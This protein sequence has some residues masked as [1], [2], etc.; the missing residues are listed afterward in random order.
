MFSGYRALE[1][2]RFLLQDPVRTNSFRKA[3]F[4]VVKEGDVV[5]DLGA[6]S[7][8]LSFF[9]YQAGAKKIYAIEKGNIIEATKRIARKN[10]M[11]DK[12]TFI[13]E[14][15]RIVRLPEKVD[16]IVSEC[17]GHFALGGSMISALTNMRD[18]YLKKG[19]VII[20][21]SISMFIV[22]VQSFRHYQHVNFWERNAAY[23]FDFHPAQ[24]MASNNVY[25]ATMKP[26]DFIAAPQKIAAMDLFRDH[27][28]EM[29]DIKAGFSIP[30]ACVMHG[31]CGWSEVDLCAGVSF[32]TSPA[33]KTTVWQQVFFPLEK[34]ISLK[35][36]SVV[37]LHLT[38]RRSE[39][40]LCS[41]L[42]WTI[43][44][45]RLGKRK[46]IARQSTKK[47]FP[48]DYKG[49]CASNECDPNIDGKERNRRLEELAR[50]LKDL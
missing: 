11:S 30:K 15:S 33:H 10:G 37:D 7:G 36:N 28:N 34:E 14:D 24:E 31:L 26:R 2:H 27:P 5:I 38:L 45:T 46:I 47:S 25:L 17:I 13:N 44:V 12:I 39:D 1:K 8:I 50:E 42:N 9:A 29:L 32:S 35:K 18:N 4:K 3:I 23:G 43:W 6:G 22:P 40:N 49:I 16:V 21:G 19:G 20:P 48:F 41:C